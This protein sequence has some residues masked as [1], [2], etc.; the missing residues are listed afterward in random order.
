[1]GDAADYATEQG[2]DA[3]SLHESGEG[4]SLDPCQICHDEEESFQRA[5]IEN[6]STDILSPNFWR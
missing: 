6:A 2:L 4:D 1:M 5:V 3:L